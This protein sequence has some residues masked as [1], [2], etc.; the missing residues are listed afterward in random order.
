MAAGLCSRAMSSRTARALSFASASPLAI[1][2]AV[3]LSACGGASTQ[4]AGPAPVIVTTPPAGD[5]SAAAPKVTKLGPNAT[6]EGVVFNFKMEGKPHQIYLAG[7]F[8]NWSKDDDRYLM[9][10]DDG[11]GIWSITVKLAPGTYQYKYVAD[12]TWTQDMEAP[13]AAPDGYGGR[14]SQLEVK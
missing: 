7:N 9:K 13:A 4:P 8:N 12:G 14:N 2:L 5:G 11:D 10:D 1:S 3:A 6:P